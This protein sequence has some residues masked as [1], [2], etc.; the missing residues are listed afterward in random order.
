MRD[1]VVLRADLWRLE[2]D[3]TRPV[4]L[5]RLPYNKAALAPN[6][7]WFRTTDCVAAGYAVVIQDTRGRFASDGEWRAIMWDQEGLDTYDTVEWIAAQP[8]CDGNVGM[9]G[10]SYLGFVQWMGAA[11]RPPHLKAIVPAISGNGKLDHLDNGGAVALNDSVSWLAFMTIDWLGRELAAGR[12]SDIEAFQA[13]MA[14]AH[15]PTPALDHLPLRE[16]PGV[17]MAG[18][19]VSLDEVLANESRHNAEFDFDAIEVPSLSIGGWFDVFAGATL[20]GF[21]RLRADGGGD[22]A[23]R[24]AHRL[25]V[26]PWVHASHLPAGQ[27]DMNFGIMA[28][29]ASAGLTEKHIAFYDRYLKGEGAELPV[30]EYFLMGADEWRTADSWPPPG[31]TTLAL[32]LRADGRLTTEPPDGD[33]GST[34]YTYDPSDPVPTH[35][36]RVCL[37]RA[38][39]GPRDQMRNEARSDV[40]VFTSEVLEEP[41]DVVGPVQASL[42]VA[43]SAPATDFVVKLTDVD[44][45]GRSIL[46]TDGILRRSYEGGA[47]RVAIPIGHTAWRFLA[48]HRIRVT[49]TSSDFP[50]WDRNLNTGHPVGTDHKGVVA[51]QTLFHSAAHPSRVELTVLGRG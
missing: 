29:G 26:G 36:G 22:D 49:V 6:S 12:S 44:A 25:I 1:G 27:G 4:I 34:T 30:V 19:P 13:I 23:T 46:V 7:D 16:M 42:A 47:E 17:S 20:E 45:A 3:E 51:D 40:V 32:H 5:R 10:G 21:N 18:G 9:N 41:V 31:A 14:I 48:G 15:D 33:E 39:T 35:G 37:G 11:Q 28:E 24:Q 50:R 2:G 8:W 38:L 43:T